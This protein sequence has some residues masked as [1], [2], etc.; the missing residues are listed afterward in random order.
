MF[1]G[2]T[3]FRQWWGENTLFPVGTCCVLGSA[4]WAGSAHTP[5]LWHLLHSTERTLLFLCPSTAVW[6]PGCFCIKLTTQMGGKACQDFQY[7]CCGQSVR[8]KGFYFPFCLWLSSP[9]EKQPG[10]LKGI[11]AHSRGLELDDLH[12]PFQPK[13]F[14][15][16]VEENSERDLFSVGMG[17]SWCVEESWGVR[18]FH[19]KS[20]SSFSTQKRSPMKNS[21]Q[22]SKMTCSLPAYILMGHYS[23]W[24]FLSAPW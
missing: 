21:E 23:D 15:D 6:L 24:K 2:M 5:G 8:W 18:N 19:A 4:V 17:L 16:S 10:L 13:P 11:P 20:L 22:R 1:F 12:G 7:R 14:Y 9:R 3:S